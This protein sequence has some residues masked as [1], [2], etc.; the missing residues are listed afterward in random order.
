MGLVYRVRVRV[1][2]SPCFNV[3]GGFTLTPSS[4][5][6]PARMFSM[7]FCILIILDVWEKLSRDEMVYPF[8]TSK[9]FVLESCT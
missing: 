9:L 6:L 1:R 5:R 7:F 2:D 8:D 3:L 4:A